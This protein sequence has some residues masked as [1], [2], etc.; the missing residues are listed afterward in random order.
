MRWPGRSGSCSPGKGSLIPWL[1]QCRQHK[2]MSTK[3]Q[4]LSSPYGEAVL[5]AKRPELQPLIDHVREVA[6]GRDD[7]RVDAPEPWPVPG[8]Q[9]P[10]DKATNSSQQGC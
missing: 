4:I 6:Q 3:D 5:T 7:I 8:S 9:A 1:A 10:P 2:G